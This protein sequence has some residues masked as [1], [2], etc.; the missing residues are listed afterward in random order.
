MSGV[1]R[2]NEELVF[3]RERGKKD[4]KNLEVKNYT[5]IYAQEMSYL[6]ILPF[7]CKSVSCEEDRN[8]FLSNLL[9]L[10]LWFC[11]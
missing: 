8:Y 7:F 1:G 11:T 6:Q 2:E 9:K 4:V 10:S 5:K 3:N